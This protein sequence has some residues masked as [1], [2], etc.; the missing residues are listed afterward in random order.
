[1]NRSLPI[2][3]GTPLSYVSRQWRQASNFLG[4]IPKTIQGDW[5][6]T[7]D[8]HLESLRAGWPLYSSLFIRLIKYAKNDP[9][10]GNCIIL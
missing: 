10:N 3:A 9:N 8:N 6:G 1:M 7:L 2:D 5:N 4:V